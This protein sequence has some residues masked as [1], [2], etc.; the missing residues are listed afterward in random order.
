MILVLVFSFLLSSCG[1]GQ[2]F[3][4]TATPTPSATLTPTST[5]TPTQTPTI[6]PTFTP[7]LTFTPTP[8]PVC[9]PGTTITSESDP[10]L[11]G[12][13]DIIQASS[14]LEGRQ[15][16]V[17][18]K[19]RE[20]PDQIEIN[21]LPELSKFVPRY[22]WGVDIDIDGDAT[23]GHQNNFTDYA[24]GIEYFMDTKIVWDDSYRDSTKI[25]NMKNPMSYTSVGELN[26]PYFPFH[27][28]TAK[29][30]VDIN[31]NT[32]SVNGYVP[33][34]TENSHLIFY[35]VNRITDQKFIYKTLCFR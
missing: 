4:P 35:A 21:K 31:Q 10:S 23:T 13:L 25:L 8:I 2:V 11:P 29:V 1:T 18:L 15:L 27:I 5:N 9:N 6:T 24:Y 28:S 32:I 3:G 19:F 14:K 26:P 20:L 33:E 30:I 12:Y 16:F 22:Q 34:I 17:T 7:T